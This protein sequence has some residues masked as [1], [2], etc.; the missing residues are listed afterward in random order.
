MWCACVCVQNGITTN[1][2]IK[3]KTFVACTTGK[4]PALTLKLSQDLF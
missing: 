1:N 4:Y 3:M 2:K